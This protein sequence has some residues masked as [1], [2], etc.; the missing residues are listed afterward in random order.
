[1]G[2]ALGGTWLTNY[3]LPPDRLGFRRAPRDGGA[4][5]ARRAISPALGLCWKFRLLGSNHDRMSAAQSEGFTAIG[6]RPVEADGDPSLQEI[7][8]VISRTTLQR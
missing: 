1:M 8:D 7:Y 5:V 6:H 3:S 4:V 2:S